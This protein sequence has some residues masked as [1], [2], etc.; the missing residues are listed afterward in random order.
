MKHRGCITDRLAK[1][2]WRDYQEVMR[3]GNPLGMSYTEYVAHRVAAGGQRFY[4]SNN[5]ANSAA[6][7]YMA[8]CGHSHP[9]GAACSFWTT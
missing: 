4:V 8:E 2:Y 3:E 5:T 9:W 7:W 1:E 6:P